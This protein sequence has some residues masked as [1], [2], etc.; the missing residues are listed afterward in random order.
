[1]KVIAIIVNLWVNPYFNRY[2]KKLKNNDGH[3]PDLDAD[4]DEEPL[5]K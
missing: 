1:M 3:I 2:R 4:L 5:I